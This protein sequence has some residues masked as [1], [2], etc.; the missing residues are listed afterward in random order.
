MISI[1]KNRL[2]PSVCACVRFFLSVAFVSAPNPKP[3][4]ELTEQRAAAVHGVFG[5]NELWD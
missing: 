5:G 2:I 1:S 3:Q 4:A